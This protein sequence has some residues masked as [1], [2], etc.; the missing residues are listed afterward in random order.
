MVKTPK[1]LFEGLARFQKLESHSSELRNELDVVSAYS[2]YLEGFP[3][4]CHA[5]EGYVAVRSFLQAHSDK[6][7]TFFAYRSRTEL[8]LLWSLLVA[9][10]PL[11]ELTRSDARSFVDFCKSPPASWVGPIVK[12]IFA[13][14]RQKGLRFRWLHRQFRVAAI[15]LAQPKAEPDGFSR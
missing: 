11:L 9:E 2:A 10:K 4:R 13:Y 15:R 6:E 7:N 1:P 12:G 5:V 8:L 14:W 3:E